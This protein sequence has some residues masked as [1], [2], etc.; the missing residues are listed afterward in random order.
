MS[1]DL[2]DLVTV[3]QSK[4]LAQRVKAELAAAQS[5][6]SIDFPANDDKLY[7]VKNG[8]WTAISESSVIAPVPGSAPAGSDVLAWVKSTTTLTGGSATNY[9]FVGSSQFCH[10]HITYKGVTYALISY[11]NGSGTSV[12]YNLFF[13]Q[14][15]GTRYKSIATI[16]T[17]STLGT[18][19]DSTNHAICIVDNIM[20]VTVSTNLYTLN[21]DCLIDSTIAKQFEEVTD[22]TAINVSGNSAGY[23]TRC[24]GMCYSPTLDLILM[25]GNG[26]ASGAT[27]SS[28]C[29]RTMTGT[30]DTGLT[31]GDVTDISQQLPGWSSFY[32]NNIYW[33]EVLGKF[34]GSSQYGTAVSSDGLNWEYQTDTKPLFYMLDCPEHHCLYAFKNGSNVPYMS[35]DGLV[36]I[37]LTAY[38]I[39]PNT[40]SPSALVYAPELGLFCAIPNGSQDYV[41]ISNDM[42]HWAKTTMPDTASR[43][44]LYWSSAENAFKCASS[45]G[46][47]ASQIVS[48]YDLTF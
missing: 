18:R 9:Y 21:L 5:G 11:Q 34:I 25:V 37:A 32:L 4:A 47:G 31:F 12:S 41:L 17:K 35:N 46:S 48:F 36:W 27:S 33:S 26:V 42:K 2:G 39:P 16:A 8:A 14:K 40:S 28:L 3:G 19:L 29:L 7:A 38:G 13:Y 30:P 22:Y 44:Y 20:Y 24:Y 1:Y 6:G 43:G 23:M 10:T 15:T 45:V